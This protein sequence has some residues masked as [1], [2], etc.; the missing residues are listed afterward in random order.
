MKSKNLEI[1]FNL[2]DLADDMKLNSYE[3]N[4]EK[5]IKYC[6]NYLR[7]YRDCMDLTILLEKLFERTKNGEYIELKSRI[8]ELFYKKQVKMRFY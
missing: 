3:T 8:K 5:I 6:E 2:S 4:E 7:D 1:M